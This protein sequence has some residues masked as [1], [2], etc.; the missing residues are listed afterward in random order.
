MLVITEPE[1]AALDDMPTE[2]RIGVL[3]NG[4]RV[5]SGDAIRKEYRA[6]LNSRSSKKGHDYDDEEE[7]RK[8]P[9]NT[10]QVFRPHGNTVHNGNSI[11][12][13]KTDIQSTRVI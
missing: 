1:D 9:Q 3:P 8:Q 13:G 12:M 10:Q 2:T 7:P 6:S 4:R 11:P 5:S